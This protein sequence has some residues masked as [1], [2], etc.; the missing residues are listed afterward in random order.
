MTTTFNREEIKQMLDD[1]GIDYSLNSNTPG[2]V[3]K[4]GT[5][6]TFNQALE[7]FRQ[8]FIYPERK[9]VNHILER[10]KFMKFIEISPSTQIKNIFE[11]ALTEGE[12]T[13]IFEP[14]SSCY[15]V[16]F[17]TG[18]GFNTVGPDGKTLKSALNANRK[19]YSFN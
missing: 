14:L 13:I 19:T 6:Q 15:K 8:Q 5:F 9:K 10:N 7:N 18:I 3:Y 11:E 12:T 2:I 17:E 1:L 4:D 16:T